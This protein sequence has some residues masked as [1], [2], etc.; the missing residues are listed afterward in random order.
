[1]YN[2]IYKENILLLFFFVIS[3]KSK[4]LYE[5]L[6]IFE[7]RNRK[8]MKK[9]CKHI[10]FYVINVQ[11]LCLFVLLR[12]RLIQILIFERLYFSRDVSLLNVK[13]PWLFH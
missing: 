1:M 2:N 9:N 5:D 3:S 12:F 7:N 11:W 4:T 10:D 6:F 13:H 8:I